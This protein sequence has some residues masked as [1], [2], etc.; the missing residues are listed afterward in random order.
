MRNFTFEIKKR[1]FFLITIWPTVF[2]PSDH[3]NQS[4]IFAFISSL[5]KITIYCIYV[6]SFSPDQQERDIPCPSRIH[7]LASAPPTCHWQYVKPLES[8][9]WQHPH[10]KM[11]HSQF[12]R[13]GWQTLVTFCINTCLLK[14]DSFSSWHITKQIILLNLSSL[15]ARETQK[16]MMQRNKLLHEE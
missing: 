8:C 13:K 2:I 5:E 3:W 15:E 6:L 1:F 11:L 12:P 4:F 7:P 14:L 10:F 16:L 9:S